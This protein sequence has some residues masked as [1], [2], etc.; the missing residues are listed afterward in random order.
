M[1][2][3]C[4]ASLAID[5]RFGRLTHV[6]SFSARRAIAGLAIIERSPRRLFDPKRHQARR[7]R[8]SALCSRNDVKD[9]SA[10]LADVDNDEVVGIWVFNEVSRRHGLLSQCALAL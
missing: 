2:E 10:L 5:L 7:L 9:I 4:R 8:Y 1:V 3:G 6:G